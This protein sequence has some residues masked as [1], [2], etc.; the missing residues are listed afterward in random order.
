MNDWLLRFAVAAVRLWTGVYTSGLPPATADAR[1]AEVESDLWES[2][3]DPDPDIR[4]HLSL[5]I[6]ARLLIGIPDDLGWRLEQEDVMTGS[7]RQSVALALCAMGIL[8]VLFVVWIAQPPFLPA[9]PGA[10]VV[11]ARTHPPPP[12]PPPS[13]PGITGAE[14]PRFVFAETSYAAHGTATTPQR[15]RDVPPVYPPIAMHAGVQGV[16][17]VEA[18][19]D[20]RGR[21]EKARVVHPAHW[22]LDQSALAAVREWEFTPAVRDGAPIPIVITARVS[23]SIPR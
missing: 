19:I 5:Q 21:I 22:V 9:L 23:F 17:V 6:A 10:P 12:P 4:S 2:A 7:V 1:R 18:V 14:D 16:V 8:G 15:L 13:Q 11:T 20:E 3:H